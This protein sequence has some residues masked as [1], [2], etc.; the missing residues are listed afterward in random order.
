MNNQLIENWEI[1]WENNQS[2]LSQRE[3]L[4]IFPEARD[5]LGYKL[6]IYKEKKEKLAF[7]IREDFKQI[8][9]KNGEYDEFTI[10][11]FEKIIEVWKGEKLNWLEKQIKKLQFLLSEKKEGKITE[12]MVEQARDYPFCLLIDIRKKTRAGSGFTL[13][14]FHSEKHPSFYITSAKGN[15]RC[16]CFGCGKSFDTIGFLMERDGLSFQDAVRKL[17][18]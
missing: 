4:E 12:A 18:N 10:W 3:L 8:Y 7:E 1:E 16:Y 2:R 17:S 13:C 14:P 5:Y 15:N 6:E 11:F 9:K